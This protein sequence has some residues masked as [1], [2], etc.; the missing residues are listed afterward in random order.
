MLL[1]VGIAGF[2][3]MSI[4]ALRA[5]YLIYKDSKTIES[6]E[7]CKKRLAQLVARKQLN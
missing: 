6:D 7:T 2:I 4:I 5:L 3:L 1:Y